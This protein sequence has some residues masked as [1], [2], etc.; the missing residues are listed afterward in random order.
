MNAL[1]QDFIQERKPS[2]FARPEMNFGMPHLDDGT[3]SG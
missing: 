2:T 1:Y 3:V